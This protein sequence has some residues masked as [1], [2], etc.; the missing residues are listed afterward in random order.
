MKKV[1]LGFIT[2]MVAHVAQA[3]AKIYIAPSESLFAAPQTTDGIT[4][5]AAGMVATTP[6]YETP[7]FTAGIIFVVLLVGLLIIFK[8]RK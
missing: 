8:V 2:M 4:A 5:E 7:V 1:I 3:Q 6:F